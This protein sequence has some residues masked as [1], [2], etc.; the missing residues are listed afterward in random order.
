MTSYTLPDTW[1]LNPRR[2]MG[3]PDLSA[4]LARESEMHGSG[5]RMVTYERG[6]AV[7]TPQVPDQSIYLLVSGEV[8]LYRQSADGRRFALATLRPGAIFGQASLLGSLEFDTYAE[9]TEPCS[10]WTMADGSA[11]ELLAR[12]VDLSMRFMAGLGQRL[13][14]VEARLESMAY[15]KVPARLASVLL[16]MMNPHDH[17]ISGMTHQRLAE[18]L[19]TYRETVSQAVRDFRKRGLVSPGRKKIVI[20]AVEELR[21]LAQQDE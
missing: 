9:A 11:R 13:T 21:E 15:K 18:I 1:D 8:C 2:T 7:Y 12:R 20:L 5:L 17:T 4:M 6:Q 3:M 14:E 19:G 16:Q 10:V